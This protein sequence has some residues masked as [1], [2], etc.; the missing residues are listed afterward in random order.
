MFYFSDANFHCLNVS[1]ET[2]QNKNSFKRYRR[3]SRVLYI[4]HL[5]GIVSKTI[6]LIFL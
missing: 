4:R 6:K 3:N 5:E 1:S 2:K